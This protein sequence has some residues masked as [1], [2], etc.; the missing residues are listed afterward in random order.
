MG[1]DGLSSN[2][3]SELD[4]LSLPARRSHLLLFEIQSLLHMFRNK[5]YEAA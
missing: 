5:L 2:P 1:E 4:S 3:L